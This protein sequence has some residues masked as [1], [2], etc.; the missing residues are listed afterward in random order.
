MIV[1]N[2]RAQTG[3]SSP[4]AEDAGAAQMPGMLAGKTALKRKKPQMPSAALA[5][6]SANP[7]I[8]VGRQWVRLQAI[9][10]SHTPA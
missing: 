8:L 6:D 3:Q 5:K 2:T 1:K 9:L 4:T 10:S 7:I